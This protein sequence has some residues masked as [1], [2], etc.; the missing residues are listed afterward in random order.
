RLVGRVRHARVRATA[1]SDRRGR[2]RGDGA[3]ESR[4]FQAARFSG[5]FEAAALRTRLAGAHPVDAGDRETERGGDHRGRGGEDRAGE[6]A[7]P[8]GARLADEAWRLREVDPRR[9]GDA[10]EREATGGR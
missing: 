6:G 2:A 3:R 5:R 9:R 1:A 10:A 7:A 4:E 8:G